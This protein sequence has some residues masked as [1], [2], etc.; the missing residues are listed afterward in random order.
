MAWADV[1][2]SVSGS[3]A[4]VFQLYA[5]ASKSRDSL[6]KIKIDLGGST[7]IALIALL[8]YLSARAQRRDEITRTTITARLH[9]DPQEAFRS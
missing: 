8:V 1:Q 4:R 6:T 5:V 7:G 3:K 9:K 2:A